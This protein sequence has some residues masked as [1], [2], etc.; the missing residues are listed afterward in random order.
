MNLS[1]KGYR[2]YIIAAVAILTVGL[3]ASGYINEADYE[4]I[5]GALTGLGLY[6]LRSAIPQE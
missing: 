2:T 5:I 1:L 4:V 3:K 6:T